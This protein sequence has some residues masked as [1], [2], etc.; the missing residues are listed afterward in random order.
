MADLSDTSK[1]QNFVDEKNRQLNAG[2]LSQQDYNAA[3]RDAKVGIDGFS[4]SMA[5][6]SAK[7]KKSVIG[8]GSS[9]VSGKSGA[10]V[11]NNAIESTADLISNALSLLGPIG[12]VLGLAVTAGAKYVAAVNQQADKLFES[13]QDI[14]RSGLAT[15]MSDTF[16]NLQ[17]F[18]YT[19][20][21]IGK[22]GELLK[23]N[24]TTLAQFGGTTSNGAAKFA[25]LAASIQDSQI[26]IEFQRMGM[27]VDDVNQGIAGYMRIQQASG[28]IGKQTNEQLTQGA[29]AYIDQ[30]NR[31]TRLTGLTAKQQNKVLE[32]ALAGERFAASQ[33]ILKQKGDVDSLAKAKSNEELV[34]WFSGNMGAEAT[35]A[36][37]KFLSGAMND[38]EIIKFRRTYGGMA[39]MHDKG[40]IDVPTLATQA[41][42]DA[43]DTSDRYY[44]FGKQG[45][46]SEMILA[47]AQTMKNA[48]R[49][50]GKTVEENNELAKKE[51][52]DAKKG[53]DPGVKAQVDLRTSQRNQT[54]ALEKLINVGISPVTEQVAKLSKGISKITGI[55][56]TVAGGPPGVGSGPAAGPAP[57]AVAGTTGAGPGT[58]ATT[59]EGLL[60]FTGK[61]GSK[62]NFDQL[63][64]AV[65]NAFLSMVAD[66]KKTV[67]INSARRAPEDQERLYNDWLAAG[68]SA[69]NPIVNIPGKGRI[70]MPAKPGTSPHEQGR[71]IDLDDSSFSGLS[72]L[73]GKHGFRTVNGDPGHI[74]MANGGVAT[75]P[76]DG[77]EATLHGTEAVIP[78]DGKKAITVQTQEDT[79]LDQQSH[80]LSMKI[81][82]LDQLI[83]GMQTHYDT[84]SKI[85]MR[86]S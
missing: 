65:K 34:V 14:S 50:Y 67:T 21:E 30:Q 38:E 11:Y 48:G 85:L 64:P 27:S 70:R 17:K 22:M 46:A 26:G 58:T 44:T 79:M 42:K 3:M 69:S 52:E 86:Q 60:K 77:Y 68:G 6:S 45:I 16:A 62:A 9:I 55:V 15:G 24:S 40:I 10:S 37:Q 8:L 19:V 81:S 66:Y 28:Q 12:K 1:I 33:L 59:T 80:L 4:A 5:A 41:I 76:K 36:L 63:D 54:Q 25:D 75:G 23:E 84:S 29:T 72:G 61:S 74:Q 43:K 13:Y 32:Q 51:I 78:M 56:S 18:G 31:L 20:A 57:A 83:K 35:S 53:E 2:T 71:A 82:K 39:E 73:F 49:A 7:L 47:P